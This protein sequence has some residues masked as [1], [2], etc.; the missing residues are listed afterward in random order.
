MAEYVA[1]VGVNLRQA[2]A[3]YDRFVG[4]LESRVLVTARR[5]RE[6][7]VSTTKDIP[8]TTPLDLETREPRTAE[9][10]APLQ[11]SLIEAEEPI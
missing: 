3:A 8:D 1:D 11:E 10:R 4:S 9:L 6:L 5:F 2:G 7:G